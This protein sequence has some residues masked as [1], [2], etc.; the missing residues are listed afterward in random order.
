[1]STVTASETTL[2]L[3]RTFAASRD[4]VFK[5][6]TDPDELQKWFHVASTWKTPIAEVDLRVG[7]KYRLG[8][9]NPEEK[10][11]TIVSGIY[12][13]IEEPEKLVYTW[14]W[15]GADSF[16]TLVTVKFHDRDGSTEVELIHERFRNV[17]ERDLHEQGW[18]GCLSN[19]NACFMGD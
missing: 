1:M 15:E 18:K 11:P 10:D 17:E 7:G 8:M 5:A 19:L 3:K 14:A 9:Q 2:H 12:K 16:E 4:L 6:W 13:E